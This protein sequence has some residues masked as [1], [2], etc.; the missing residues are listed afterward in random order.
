[1]TCLPACISASWKKKRGEL[2]TPS[3]YRHDLILVPTS[4]FYIWLQR[5]LGDQLGT[6]EWSGGAWAIY[7]IRFFFNS[8]SGNLCRGPVVKTPI[9]QKIFQNFKSYVYSQFL[10][11]SICWWYNCLSYMWFDFLFVVLSHDILWLRIYLE[12]LNHPIICL[13]LA[14]AFF[15][16]LFLWAIYAYTTYIYTHIFC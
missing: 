11:F 10:K 14:L 13:L 7:T 15:P 6:Q 16:F 4:M 2:A 9:A 12:L 5:L 3:F 8:F 1:M